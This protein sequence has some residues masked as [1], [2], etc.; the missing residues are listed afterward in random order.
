MTKKPRPQATQPNVEQGRKHH[1]PNNRKPKKDVRVAKLTY[2]G[3]PVEQESHILVSLHEYFPK[4]F[5]QQCITVAC[6]MV[7]IKIEEPLKS[8]DITIKEEKILTSK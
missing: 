5:F 2:A 3:E 4:D 1:R 6:H 8:K 7:E